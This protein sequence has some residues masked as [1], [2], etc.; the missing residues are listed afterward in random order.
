MDGSVSGTTTYQPGDTGHVRT[1]SGPWVRIDRSSEGT[2]VR[3]RPE[4]A[5]GMAAMIGM[6]M[7]RRRT[8]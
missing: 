1:R 4:R 6:G 8:S 2:D 5:T 3:P 7:A